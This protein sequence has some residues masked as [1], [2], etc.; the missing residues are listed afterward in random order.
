MVNYIKT[1]VVTGLCAALVCGCGMA[2]NRLSTGEA[3]MAA[4]SGDRPTYEPD[5]PVFD[6]PEKD[7]P[8]FKRMPSL[9]GVGL[10]RA[11]IRIL[12]E[13]KRIYPKE[14]QSIYGESL[15]TNGRDRYGLFEFDRVENMAVQPKDTV[16]GF[17]AYTPGFGISYMFWNRTDSVTQYKLKVTGFHLKGKRYSR[18]LDP[19]EL[20]VVRMLSDNT[21][22][23]NLPQQHWKRYFED[24]LTTLCFVTR[25]YIRDGVITRGDVLKLYDPALDLYQTK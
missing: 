6:Y 7:R 8:R 12:K 16:Y 22:E 13:I 3:D 1:A 4:E 11:D 23:Q 19:F 2:E 20:D 14:I 18:T 5:L 17:I 21:I 15:F 9:E 24:Y 25:L 10:K